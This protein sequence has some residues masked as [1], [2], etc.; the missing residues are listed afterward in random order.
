MNL[1]IFFRDILEGFFTK[2]YNDNY[3]DVW[4][5]SAELLSHRQENLPKDYNFIDSLKVFIT[6]PENKGFLEPFL[7][8]NNL[9]KWFRL[10]QKFYLDNYLEK[11]F[12][13][14]LEMIKSNYPKIMPS[15]SPDTP[16]KDLKINT[17]ETRPPKDNRSLSKLKS[18]NSE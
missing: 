4:L 2:T 14:S 18:T 5:R 6:N 16:I 15:Q 10:N 1:I 9:E 13:F 17:P 11:E 3:M 7:V 12:G 8:Y